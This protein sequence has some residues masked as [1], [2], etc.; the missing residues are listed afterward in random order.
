MTFLAPG[1]LCSFMLPALWSWVRPSNLWRPEAGY[2][3]RFFNVRELSVFQ[4]WL[5]TKWESPSW[6]SHMRRDS[7]CPSDALLDFAHYPKLWQSLEERV[8]C[9]ITLIVSLSGQTLWNSLSLVGFSSSLYTKTWDEVVYMDDSRGAVR[10]MGSWNREGWEATSDCVIEQVTSW[11]LRL[12]QGSLWEMPE[13]VPQSH[14]SPGGC[15]IHH[16]TMCHWSRATSRS[17]EILWGREWQVMTEDIFLCV[18]VSAPGLGGTWTEST[19]HSLYNLTFLIYHH[20]FLKDKYEENSY[21]KICMSTLKCLSLTHLSTQW[22]SQMLALIHRDTELNSHKYKWRAVCF[23]EDLMP[24][25]VLTLPC[26][27]PICRTS[28]GMVRTKYSLPSMY[29]AVTFL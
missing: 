15:I 24:F 28:L 3:A 17:R 8:P 19:K 26:D 5:R 29:T 10:G 25:M 6:R 16:L 22:S 11:Q 2:R 14:L 12:T 9:A 7:Q 21:N 18:E 23:I 27:F 1:Q 20:N 4:D 13:N